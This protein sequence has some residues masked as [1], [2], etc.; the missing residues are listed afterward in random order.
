[1]GVSLGMLQATL[2][3]LCY[4]LHNFRRCM[5]DRDKGPRC[6]RV[7]DC[8]NLLSDHRY[9]CKRVKALAMHGLNP[10]PIMANFGEGPQLVREGV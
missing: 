9:L 10:N 7:G 1:M 4:R 5:P 2:R 6:A 3:C 8:R